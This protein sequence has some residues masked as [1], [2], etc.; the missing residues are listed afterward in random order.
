MKINE[1]GNLFGIIS[2]I[3]FVLDALLI[4]Q[5]V[6]RSLSLYTVAKRRGSLNPG[7]AWVP[8]IWTW[9]LGGICD[10]YDGRRGIQRKWRTVL[11][12]T[13]VIAAAGFLL[14]YGLILVEA[15]RFDE[16]SQNL[17]YDEAVEALA[18]SLSSFGG[19][20]VLLAVMAIAA[21]AYNVCRSICLFKLFE[22]CR[23]N[24][25]VKLLLLSLVVPFAE[26]FCLISCKNYDLGLQKQE[27]PPY[28]P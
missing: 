12:T 5:Y 8:V 20:Y 4:V 6:L 25:A 26:P 3:T 24:D 22:S 28:N 7:Y 19:T 27:L 1:L 15:F 13:T 9:T 14:A 2:M 23:P 21:S 16:I 17:T 11:L 18:E 10:Q